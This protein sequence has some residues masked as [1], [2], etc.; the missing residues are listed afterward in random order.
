M[1]SVF[2][3]GGGGGQTTT[4][5]NS[6]TVTV[7]PEIT[8]TIINDDSRLQALV[9]TLAAGNADQR[10]ALTMQAE[11][12]VELARAQAAV[13]EKNAGTISDTIKSAVLTAVIGF[14][15]TQMLRRG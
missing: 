3:G 4:V 8:N 9:D 5:S 2:G 11:A 1:S 15:V 14:A 6:T 13:A 7:N 10:Q 12:A